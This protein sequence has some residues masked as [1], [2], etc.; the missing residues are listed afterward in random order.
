M[1]ARPQQDI[2]LPAICAWNL[3]LGGIV[4][5]F[6]D[7]PIPDVL[8][9]AV[10]SHISPDMQSRVL[11]SLRA[12][13]LIEHN[14]RV[15]DDLKRLISARNTGQW[16]NQLN[17]L[18]QTRYP[19]IP[20]HTLPQATSE[21]LHAAFKSHIKRET[22]NLSKAEAFYLNLAR[23]AGVRLSDALQKRVST[24][25]TMA[26][27]RAARKDISPP[28]ATR[29]EIN[30]K[31]ETATPAITGQERVEKIMELLRMFS[32]EGLPAKELEAVLTLLDYAKRK[33]A[34]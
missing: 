5:Y 6:K 19:Y 25:D 15:R 21:T 24:A 14:G 2:S 32:G 4:D 12:L 27:V 9:R 31:T 17:I 29:K 26:T 11:T 20:V 28:A 22:T 34:A 18:L 3:F 33:A 1:L 16:E 7:R 30:V 23:A 13:N 8:E 10:L